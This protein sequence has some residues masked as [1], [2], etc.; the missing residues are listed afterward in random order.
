MRLL[1]TKRYKFNMI[2]SF[3]VSL[4]IGVT[5]SGILSELP[6]GNTLAH[7]LKAF[8]AVSFFFVSYLYFTRRYRKRRKILVTPFPAEW[9]EIL[10]KNVPFYSLLN[11]EDRNIFQKKIQLFLGGVLITGIGVEIDDLTRVLVA[12][13]AVIPV[14]KVFDW[15]YTQV[16]DIFVCPDKFNEYFPVPRTKANILG[17]VIHNKSSVYLSRESLLRGFSKTDGSNAG[18]HEFMHKIDEGSGDIDGILPP[19]FLSKDER[20]KWLEIVDNE[21]K[22]V[23]MSD[24]ILH[25]YSLNSRAEFTAVAVEF[26][27]ERPADLKERHPALYNIMK[28]IFRQ[29]LISSTGSKAV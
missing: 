8:T 21:M 1:Y 27:F 5:V 7:D 19:P 18:I 9:I 16:T 22:R 14:F 11:E 4:L 13:G 29:N 12:S 24:S 2:F 10:E 17:M 20:L 3:F 28:R 15:E 25:P 23:E 26:F 6:D